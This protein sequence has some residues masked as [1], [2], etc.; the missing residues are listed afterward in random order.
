MIFV[1]CLRCFSFCL[2]ADIESM[3]YCIKCEH[4]LMARQLS[5]SLDQFFY[6]MRIYHNV[7]IFSSVDFFLLT[8]KLHFFHDDNNF[9]NFKNFKFSI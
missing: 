7:C 8:L 9:I 2:L 3:C 6:S 4:S 5:D 1:F